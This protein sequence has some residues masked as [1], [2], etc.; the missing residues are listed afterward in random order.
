MDSGLMA[1]VI[2][3]ISGL[4]C[5][6]RIFMRLLEREAGF[7]VFSYITV[8]CRRLLKPVSCADFLAVP[9]S[10]L[11]RRQINPYTV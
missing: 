3:E 5:F 1:I 2:Y 9:R 6:Y 4:L 7:P 10:V 11:P 8:E